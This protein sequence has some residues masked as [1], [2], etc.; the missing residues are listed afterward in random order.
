MK[1]AIIGAGLAGLTSAY[2]NP[3]GATRR[4]DRRPCEA[5][6]RIGGKLFTVAFEAGPTDMGAE[7]F[8]YHRPEGREFF[9]ELGLANTI[10]FPSGLRSTVDPGGQLPDLPR[11]G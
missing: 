6:D 5:T 9:T 10:K 7:A 1:F 11:V 4:A 2:R 3:Q 8:L